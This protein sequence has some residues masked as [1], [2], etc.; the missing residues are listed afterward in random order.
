MKELPR[1]INS[2]YLTYYFEG[3]TIKKRFDDFNN[4]TEIFEN[5][6]SGEMKLEEEKNCRIYLN[7]I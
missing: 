2:D 5:I 6:Q 7:Q 3:N 4:G 1:E